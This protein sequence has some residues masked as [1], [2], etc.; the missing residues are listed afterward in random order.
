MKK[1]V[2]KD[3]EIGRLA[4]EASELHK[5]KKQLMELLEQRDLEIREKSA[6]IKS[7]LDKIVSLNVNSSYSFTVI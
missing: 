1:Q 5:S 2:E 3:G 7:Y 4:M 6:T